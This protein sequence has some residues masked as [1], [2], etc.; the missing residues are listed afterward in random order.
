MGQD[1]S[2][3][4]GTGCLTKYEVDCILKDSLLLYV[5]LAQ[6]STYYPFM[7][8]CISL[9]LSLSL[10]AEFVSVCVCVTL[11][12]SV[13]LVLAI[14]NTLPLHSILTDMGCTQS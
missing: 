1:F 8:V 5:R 9:T 13:C 14:T 3:T 10:F 11:S 4:D 6:L 2:W 7:H 12:L